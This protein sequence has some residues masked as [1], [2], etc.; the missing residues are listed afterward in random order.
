MKILLSI[1]AWLED[2]TGLWK[3]MAPVLKHPIPQGTDWFYVFGSAT[4][5]AFIIQVVTGIALA[6]VYTPSANAAHQSLL[7][8]THQAP[9]G[10]FVRGM[11]WWGA[12][13]M[14][15]FIGVHV[16]RVF[17][18]GSFK[19]PR[20]MSWLTGVILFL[21]VLGLGFTGQLLRWDENAIYTIVVGAEQAGRTPFIGDFVGR[22]LL[23]GEFVGAATMT[24]YFSW[25][26]FVFPGIIFGVLGIHLFLV[27][28]NGISEPA[29]AGRPVD[30]G[31]YRQ[32]YKNLLEREGRPF[33]PDALW[34]DAVFGLAVLG[35]VV[36]L[37][38]LVGAPSLGRPPNPA[39]FHVVPRP[40]WYFMW[41]FAVLALIPHH[42]TPYMIIGGPAIALLVVVLLPFLFRSG[43][44]AP[45]RRPWAVGSI[46]V[47]VIGI[48]VL[49]F[50]GIK[51]PWSPAFDA[52]PLTAEII[53]AT[54]G[55]V[56]R[57]GHQFNYRGCLFCHT[58]SGHGGKRGPDLT[59]I[60]N[61]LTG[62]E[63][64]I[65]IANG[66]YNMPEFASILSAQDF[67]DL[68]TF[69]RSRREPSG[70]TPEPPQKRSPTWH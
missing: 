2:R 14:M 53:G 49:W 11:H 7:Y 51:A 52:K 18:T 22:F 58:I 47:I 65:R 36:I 10:S 4:L 68:V 17:L 64:M 13:A 20:E 5:I 56:A 43:E 60:G 16:V 3:A 67:D 26:V 31:T 62:P 59:T 42:L 45:S 33:F 66:G 21:A 48:G 28:R 29:K 40:D 63:M 30:P 46:I 54:S 24:R 57:G 69:L 23:G 70:F 37:A 61:R 12:S 35:V 15:L 6:L 25:H 39:N 44:R 34:R 32:W 38:F 19:F 55:P 1:A 27:I 41:Y 8:I 9:L 50:I